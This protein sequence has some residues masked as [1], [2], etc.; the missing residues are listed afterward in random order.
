MFARSGMTEI[1]K[2]S[3]GITLIAGM[4]DK[5]V[6]VWCCGNQFELYAALTKHG[7]DPE[8]NKGVKIFNQPFDMVAF[9]QGRS[10]PPRR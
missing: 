3:A 4:R 1:A 6:G 5:T 2:K 8:H 9:L 7:M 10:R